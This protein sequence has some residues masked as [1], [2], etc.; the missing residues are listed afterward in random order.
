MKYFKSAFVFL[1]LMTCFIGT[2]FSQS[3]SSGK[4]TGTIIDSTTKSPIE[5]VALSLLKDS[6]VISGAET[7]PDGNFTIDNIPNGTYDLRISMIGYAPKRIRNIII[8][9]ENKIRTLN[10]ITM[11]GD[12]STEEIIVEAEKPAIEFKADKKIFNVEKSLNTQGG[13]ALDVLKN[14]PSVSVDNDGNV[15]LRGSQNVKILIDGKA[16]GLDGQNRAMILQQLPSSQI[17]NVELIT[18]PSAKYDAEGVSGII[19][20]IT[21]KSDILGYN[22]G[23]TLNMGSQDKYNSSMNFNVKKNKL[24]FF[25]SYDFRRY[26]SENQGDESRTNFISSSLTNSTS[27]GNFRMNGHFVK[28][29]IDYTFDKKNSLSLAVNYSHRQRNSSA[30]TNY[31]FTDFEN[32]I[33]GMDNLTSN[34]G[35][36][37]SVDATLS[38]TKKF[39]KENQRLDAD[40]IYSKFQDD[41]TTDVNEYLPSV[42]PILQNQRSKTDFNNVIL[43]I[44]YVNPFASDNKLETGTKFTYR[45][46]QRDYQLLNYDYTIGGFINDLNSSNTFNYKEQIYAGYATY[47]GKIK[48]F[49]YNLGL[50]G[51]GTFTN[52]DLVTTGETF[53]K[54]YFDLFPSVSLS[55]KLGKEEDLQ[56]SYSRRINRPNN[57]VL[58]PFKTVQDPLNIFSGNPDLKPEYTNSVELSFIKYLASTLITPSVYYRYTSNMMSYYQTINDSNVAYTTFKNYSSSKTYGAEIVFNSTLFRFWNLNGNLNYFKSKIDATNIENNLSNDSYSWSGRLISSMRLPNIFDLQIT[59]FYS[60]KMLIAQG[61]IDPFQ[62]MDVSIKRDLFN[63]KL[64]VGF[65]VQDVFNSM[66]FKIHGSD[67]TKVVDISQKFNQRA[68]FLTLTYRF[69]VMDNTKKEQRRKATDDTGNQQMQPGQM[70]Y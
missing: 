33:S 31:I 35:H 61:Y 25:G 68:A 51:E 42:S 1:F 58:N 48:N 13:N 14:L 54:Q 45:D 28:T 8:D 4:I 3:K 24:N 37:F 57:W 5:H 67:A 7:L 16:S 41:F 63:N 23:I 52:G 49:S 34:D 50:R 27:T 29:G 38:Y 65:R 30:K 44:D 11:T 70:G 39:D 19:N 15:S 2:G 60:G 43:Q 47:S 32:N 40:L 12:I 22:G 62:S 10:Q 53:D 17:E 20:I 46:N 18:S 66:K 55:Q 64:T 59:Y 36:G 26:N 21:K 69:G 56:L 9:N 6:T